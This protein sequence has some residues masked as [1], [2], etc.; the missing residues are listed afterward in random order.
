MC[1]RDC[2]NCT[3]DDCIVDNVTGE[4]I[5]SGNKRDRFAEYDRKYGEKKA[6][7]DYERSERGKKRHERYISSDKGKEMLKRKTEKYI[8]SGKNAENCSNYYYRKKEAAGMQG[9]KKKMECVFCGNTNVA[10]IGSVVDDKRVIRE[11]K[12]QDCGKKFYS[13]EIGTAFFGALRYDY[14]RIRDEK[15]KG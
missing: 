10:V 13:E 6:R 5:I 4:E 2:F 1:N 11:R 3:Y 14:N 9:N 15:Y 12:C 7:A 8:L